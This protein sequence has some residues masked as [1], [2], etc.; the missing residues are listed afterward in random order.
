VKDAVADAEVEVWV[1]AVSAFDSLSLAGVNDE[2][3]L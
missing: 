1:G 2:R 3:L